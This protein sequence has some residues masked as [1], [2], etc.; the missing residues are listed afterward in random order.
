MFKRS[1]ERKLGFAIAATCLLFSG[2]AQSTSIMSPT[3]SAPTGSTLGYRT[4][5]GSPGLVEVTVSE[6]NT[7]LLEELLVGDATAPGGNVELGKVGAEPATTLTGSIGGSTITLSGLIYS[8]WAAD[9]GALAEAYIIAAGAEAGLDLTGTSDLDD[10]KT[11]F[12]EADPSKF[13]PWTRVSDPNIGYVNLGTNGV[14]IGLQG[15]FNASPVLS[16]LFDMT[17]PPNLQASEVVKVTYNGDTRYLYGFNATPTNQAT[18][19]GSHSGNYEVT[20]VPIPATLMLLLPGL[21]LL[22]RRRSA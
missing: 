5:G 8:D 22:W 10:I 21:A 1:V 16:I 17:L 11:D 13:R 4:T 18:N 12:L 6:S 20:F 9:S 2:V 7:T 14:N 19:D 15:F 3:L